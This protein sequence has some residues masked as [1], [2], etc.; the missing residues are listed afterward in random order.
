MIKAMNIKQE[1]TAR[2]TLGNQL[3]AYQIEAELINFH[4]IPPLKDTV[5]T[6]MTS[7]EQFFGYYIESQLTGFISFEETESEID[8]C[9]MVVHPNF[10]RKGIA[11][12]LIQYILHTIKGHKK[13]TVMTGEKNYPAKNLY[14]SLGFIKVKT[15]EVADGIFLSGFEK[16]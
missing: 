9:R 2:E 3:P 4:E 5:E 13:I 11:K 7:R 15:V 1:E 8:I 14:L 16:K 6:I 12:K 10:F